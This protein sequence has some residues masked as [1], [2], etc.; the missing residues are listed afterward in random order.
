[1]S[2]VQAST[3]GAI[4]AVGSIEKCIGEISAFTSSV[5]GS[6][7]QQRHATLDISNNVASAARETSKIVSV[8][9][10]VVDD[11]AA[12]RTAAETVLTA[13]GSVE[14]AIENLLGEVETFLGNVASEPT[15]A[16]RG[17]R[18]A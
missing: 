9:G 6:I 1:I 14:S 7:E 11:A 12:T 5:A 17:H 2:A 16:A 10:E 8:L 15:I 4:H 18:A 13:S 3:G